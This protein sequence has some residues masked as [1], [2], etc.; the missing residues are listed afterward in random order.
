M[1]GLRKPDADPSPHS[2]VKCNLYY[3]RANYFI[4]IVGCFV[5]SFFR[6]PLA[7]GGVAL[8][9]FS[10]LLLND[11]FA[12]SVSERAVRAARKL[13][14]PLAAAMRTPA[15]AA[16]PGRPFQRRRT[17]FIC[18]RD[19]RFVVA[20]L[21]LFSGGVLWATRAAQTMALTAGAI[22]GGTLLHASMRSPNLKAKLSSYNEA[23]P[24]ARPSAEAIRCMCLS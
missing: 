10:T 15:A 5:I 4:Y 3:Y 8:A 20:G 13:H 19:R 1:G 2:R 6:N 7:F 14:P 18:G 21:Y 16:P 9:G 11:S 22:L 23:I 24:H 12:H 17:V